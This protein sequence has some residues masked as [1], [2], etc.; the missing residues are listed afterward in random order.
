ML[1]SIDENSEG[2]VIGKI[3]IILIQNHSTVYFLTE[4]CRTV[5]LHDVGIYGFT[6]VQG[7]YCCV[8]QDDLIDYYPLPAYTFSDMAV[9]VPH[10]SFLSVYSHDAGANIPTGLARRI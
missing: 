10:H 2:L 8:K 1:V 9:I 7:C 3:V 4:K 5:F 6:P